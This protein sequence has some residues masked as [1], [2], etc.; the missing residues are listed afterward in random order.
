MEEHHIFTSV[1]IILSKS[2]YQTA[3]PL[4]W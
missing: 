2:F 1:C 4:H 3:E